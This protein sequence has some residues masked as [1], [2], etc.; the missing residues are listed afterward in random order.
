M[1]GNDARIVLAVTLAIGAGAAVGFVNGILM[2]KRNL[3]SFILTLGTAAAVQG[4]GLLYTGGTASGVIAPWFQ[5]MIGGRPWG[6]I[7][8]VVPIFVAVAACGLLIQNT[9]AFGGR[10]YLVGSNIRRH[11]SQWNRRRPGADRGLYAERRGRRCR[12]RR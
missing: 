12:R 5:S 4:L 2:A 7:P 3:P 9:T 11:L 8:G 1:N 6:H 10:L